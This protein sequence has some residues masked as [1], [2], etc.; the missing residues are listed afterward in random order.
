MRRTVVRAPQ[1]G[2]VVDLRFHTV[3][4]VIGP[5]EPILDL[6]PRRD[7]LIVEARLRPEDID[8][9]HAGLPAQVRLTAFK[10]RVTPTVDGE[11]IL[12]SADRLKDD[13]SGEPYYEARIEIDPASL[14]ALPD[15]ALHPGMPAEAIIITGE[16]TALDYLLAPITQS[17]QRALLE[18]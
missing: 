6:T 4:G 17:M 9:V 14:D 7:R 2:I 5:G 12:V 1:D 11:V 18:Q 8:V 10:Q 13:A 15:A 3:G 16:R